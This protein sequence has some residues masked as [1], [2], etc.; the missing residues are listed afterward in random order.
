[1]QIS[2]NISVTNTYTLSNNCYQGKNGKNHSQRDWFDDVRTRETRFLVLY[3]KRY[4]FQTYDQVVEKSNARFATRRID[5]KLF[6]LN[7]QVT[8]AI[9]LIH[10]LL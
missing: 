5:C 4:H 2:V 9:M 3:I 6:V 8:P 7:Y 1:M 10:I